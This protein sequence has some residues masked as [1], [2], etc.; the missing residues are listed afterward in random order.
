LFFCSFSGVNYAETLDNCLS[1][2][3][4]NNAPLGYENEEGEM[5]GV[6][7]EYLTALEKTT[8]FCIRKSFLPYPRLWHS[9]E[10]GNHDGG[11]VFKSDSRSHLVEYAVLIRKVKTV[12]I[13]ANGV[14]IKDYND[15]QNIVIGKTRGT[16]LSEQFDQDKSLMVIELN[17]YEQAV[18][19]LKYGRIDAI[20]GS[21]LVLSYQLKNHEIF[22]EVDIGNKWVLG[23]KEQWLQFSKKSK[24]L[25]KVGALK[26]AVEKLQLNGTFDHIM[27]KYYGEEW[28]QI[29]K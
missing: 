3:V 16:H 19:M 20:A 27:N 17:N 25:D 8:S 24:K 21:A 1:F 13:P 14:S 4:I 15:L 2:H 9:I 6:H 29:N 26:Q 7:W 12:V 18:L 11:I 5:Q 22:D 28:Q 23:E 10:S